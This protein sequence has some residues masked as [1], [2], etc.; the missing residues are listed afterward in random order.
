MLQPLDNTLINDV[1]MISLI[2]FTIIYCIYT[3]IDTFSKIINAGPYT[4]IYSLCL[5]VFFV[6]TSLLIFFLYKFYVKFSVIIYALFVNIFSCVKFN[7]Y[8]YLIMEH[9]IKCL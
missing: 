2:A 1:L 9:V 8:F 6:V 3:L 5:S 7:K 4:C